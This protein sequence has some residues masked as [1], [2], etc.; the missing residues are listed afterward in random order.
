MLD[1]WLA[2]L[3][4]VVLLDSGTIT[5]HVWEDTTFNDLITV[6]ISDG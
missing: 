3:I 4:I 5:N 2:T 6:I 1:N